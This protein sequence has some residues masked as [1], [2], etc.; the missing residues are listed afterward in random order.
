M[1]NKYE[2]EEYN[3]VEYKPTYREEYPWDDDPEE[4][5]TNI[6]I[7][8]KEIE[9]FNTLTTVDLNQDPF[10]DIEDEDLKIELE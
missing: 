8:E 5:D 9:E 1:L 2:I 6:F 3:T 10:P 4:A 7:S